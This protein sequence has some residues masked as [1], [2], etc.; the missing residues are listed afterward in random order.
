MVDLGIANLIFVGLRLALAW[1]AKHTHLSYSPNTRL[2]R[3]GNYEIYIPPRNGPAPVSVTA[4]TDSIPEDPRSP[5]LRREGGVAGFV[6]P[7]GER[8]SLQASCLVT[9]EFRSA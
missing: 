7:A 3:F 9:S 1:N 2:R 4:R 6:L 5:V 8:H